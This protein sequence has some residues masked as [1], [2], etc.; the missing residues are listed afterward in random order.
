MVIRIRPQTDTTS[1]INQRRRCRR[2]RC[3]T[4]PCVLDYTLYGRIM[5]TKWHWNASTELLRNF[6][7]VWN[8]FSIYFRTS[9]INFSCCIRISPISQKIWWLLICWFRSIHTWTEFMRIRANC[10][11]AFSYWFALVSVD[12]I[13]TWLNA[14]LAAAA[15][16]FFAT[17]P[18]GVT[19]RYGA[20][21]VGVL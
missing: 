10:P 13:L 5:W 4:S 1:L 20:F 3:S 18:S 7:S 8:I 2:N 12:W 9:S 17:N 14:A 11:I 6:I 16:K 19:G 21:A 15:W